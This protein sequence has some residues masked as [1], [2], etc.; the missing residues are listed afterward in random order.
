[1][2]YGSDD[3]EK[4]RYVQDSLCMVGYRLMEHI[5]SRC[6]NMGIQ[7]WLHIERDG[8]GSAVFLHTGM[9]ESDEFPHRFA[10]YDEYNDEVLDNIVDFGV[11]RVLSIVDHSKR[12]TDVVLRDG[13]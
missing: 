2:N 1:M 13:V 10:G 5:G 7:H 8:N 4:V 6:V 9:N 12:Y 11:Y 3:I